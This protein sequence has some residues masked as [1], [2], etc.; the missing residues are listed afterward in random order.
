VT[1]WREGRL[2]SRQEATTG[3]SEG[4]HAL[5][6]KVGPLGESDKLQLELALGRALELLPN[7]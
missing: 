7:G 1:W 4:F 6:D 2:A 5:L 3:L